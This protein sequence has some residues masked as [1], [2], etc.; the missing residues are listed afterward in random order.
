VTVWPDRATV[1]LH[2]LVIGWS[3]GKVNVRGQVNDA[4]PD[5]PVGSAAVTVGRR[6]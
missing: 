5:A 4:E 3:P 2:A 6:N 1:P